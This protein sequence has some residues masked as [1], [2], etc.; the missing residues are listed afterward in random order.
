VLTGLS[1]GAAI[2]SRWFMAALVPCALAAVVLPAWPRRRRALRAAASM[3]AATFISFVATTPF[4]FPDF[5]T[6]R[7]NLNAERTV[8]HSV[9]VG[10]SPPGNARWY[11]GNAIPA[12]MTWAIWLLALAGII[13]ALR[14][15]VP[16]QLMLVGYCL[17]F[18]VGISASDLHWQRWAIEM[19]PVLA[20]F[21]AY[22]VFVAAEWVGARAP[23]WTH[24]NTIS[25]VVAV[26]ALAVVPLADLVH[27]NRVDSQ[28]TSRLLAREWIQ[29]NVPTGSRVAQTQLLFGLHTDE[30]APIGRGIRVD[31][32]LDPS[33]PLSRYRSEGVDYIATRHGDPYGAILAGKAHPA[34]AAFYTELA[35]KTRV[36]ASV[37][38]PDRRDDFRID[39]YRLDEPPVRLL[40]LFCQQP[41]PATS[42]N[43]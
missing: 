1:V 20:L 29:D 22:T 4:F 18:L 42:S 5:S 16:Y 26:A 13:I 31:Y 27:T 40:D 41:I 7:R 37:K 38:G 14:K 30:I 15:R 33:R 34:E 28:P 21:A 35:C 36:V 25:A 8:T 12:A 19:I 17:L 9:A 10:F 24:A 32:D 2:S 23:T 39:I 11:L 43:R 3:L 6:A